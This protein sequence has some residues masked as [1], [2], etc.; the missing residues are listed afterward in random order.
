MR[1]QPAKQKWSSKWPLKAETHKRVKNSAPYIYL[2]SWCELTWGRAAQMEAQKEKGN[3]NGISNC[4]SAWKPRLQSTVI[5]DDCGL[6]F[7]RILEPSSSPAVTLFGERG[8]RDINVVLYSSCLWNECKRNID[9]KRQRI[10]LHAE[11]VL[12]AWN[13]RCFSS[14]QQCVKIQWTLRNSL[15]CELRFSSCYLLL[16]VCA[17]TAGSQN[18]GTNK[19][20][21]C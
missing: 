16:F 1:L 19:C 14:L 20:S 15:C 3:L 17:I 2:G 18:N 13:R 11:K 7:F 10:G 12:F 5:S 4:V 21:H 8:T 9:Q 6:E